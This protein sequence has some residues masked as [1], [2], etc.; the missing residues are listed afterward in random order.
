MKTKFS[1]FNNE[2]H[3]TFSP[4]MSAQDSLT[5]AQSFATDRQQGFELMDAQGR[6]VSSVAPNPEQT[7]VFPW[8]KKQLGL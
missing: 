5:Y 1:I 7:V 6:V 2:E 4:N 3:H 8:A